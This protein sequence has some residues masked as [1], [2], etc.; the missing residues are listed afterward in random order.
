MHSS[1][2]LYTLDLWPYCHIWGFT[3]LTYIHLAG[4]L[5]SAYL[6]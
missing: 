5:V 3:Q 2:L 6:C 1:I 4:M